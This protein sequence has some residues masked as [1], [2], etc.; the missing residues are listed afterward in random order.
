MAQ[1]INCEA[2]LHP[3]LHLL[4]HLALSLEPNVLSLIQ[5]HL[6]MPS[7]TRG[8]PDMELYPWVQRYCLRLVEVKYGHKLTS[9]HDHLVSPQLC[10][11]LLPSVD[12]SH[13]CSLP[14]LGYLPPS[15]D[16][17]HSTWHSHSQEGHPSPLPL[18]SWWVDCARGLKPGLPQFLALLNSS[19]R[20]PEASTGYFHSFV[21]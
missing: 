18:Q 7:S 3:G 2:F 16:M 12:E 9:T 11:M 15:C 10:R 21:F 19:C 8:C 6:R 14:P 17:A 5:E 13:H 4:A 20:G 1:K